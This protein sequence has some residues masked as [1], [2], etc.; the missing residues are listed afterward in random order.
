MTTANW[1]EANQSVLVA[2]FARLRTRIDGAGQEDAARELASV[3]ANIA[4]PAAIDLLAEAFELTPFE[5]DVLLLCAGIAMDAGFR[6]G[7]AR[8]VR[9][10]KRMA[11][12]PSVSP[13]RCWTGLI[14]VH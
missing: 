6:R 8:R 5:R 7:H 11:T 10:H 9:H 2:E 12:R 4:R 1:T 14:G 3:R 13:S